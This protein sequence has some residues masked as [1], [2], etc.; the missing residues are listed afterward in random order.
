VIGAHLG[1]IELACG[2]TVAKAVAAKIYQRR[3]GLF[4]IG[5][6]TSILY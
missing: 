5:C 3:Y 1:D 4:A 6:R 2:G